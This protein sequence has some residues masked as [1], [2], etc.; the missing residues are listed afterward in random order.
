MK[1]ISITLIIIHYLNK[2][3]L[4]ILIYV[5]VSNL[6]DNQKC[7]FLKSRNRMVEIEST[8]YLDCKI[9]KR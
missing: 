8:F 2:L 1:K 6:V 3:L 7:E 9:G 5:I 4:I